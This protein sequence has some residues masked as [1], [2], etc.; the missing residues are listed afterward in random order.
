MSD[1]WILI[2]ESTETVLTF[3]NNDCSEPITAASTRISELLRPPPLPVVF[4][5]LSLR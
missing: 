5:A 1:A 3:L 4:P 2:A